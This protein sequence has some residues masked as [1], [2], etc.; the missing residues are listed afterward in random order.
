MY[1]ENFIFLCKFPRHKSVID[2]DLP[3]FVNKIVLKK[4]LKDVDFLSVLFLFRNAGDISGDL[5]GASC[6]KGSSGRLWHADV[7]TT[8]WNQH[9][10]VS[11]D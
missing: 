3:L 1:V 5:E 2:S 9:C 8:G 7:S 10:F 6:K 4:S 11:I